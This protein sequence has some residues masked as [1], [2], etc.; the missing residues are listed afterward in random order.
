MTYGSPV[1]LWLLA[2][3]PVLAGLL[4]LSVIRRR[5]RLERLVSSELLPRLVEGWAPAS[6][7]A[8]G[9][10]RIAAIALIIL[11]LARPQWGRKDEAVV[12]RGVDIVLALDLSASMLAE[13]VVPNRLEQ[14]RA[15]AISLLT[16]LTGDRVAV[17][18]FG[19]R[20]AVHCPLT[21]DYGAAR[22]F[23]EA[24]DAAFAPAA[25]T[26]M[27]RAIES[28]RA[29]L[30]APGAGESGFKVIV[31]LTD[32]EDHEGGAL[33]A[34]RKARQ[35]G[36]VVHAV[37]VG[38]TRG[39]PIPLREEEGKLIGYKKDR[40]GKVV[41]TRLD[42]ALLEKLASSTDGTWVRAGHL[43]DAGGVIARRIAE[44][45][46][47]D[48]ASRLAARFEDRFQVPLFGAL[49][50]LGAEILWPSRRAARAQLARAL[51]AGGLSLAAAW[52]GLARGAPDAP[53]P[54]SG[55][56]ERSRTDREAAPPRPDAGTAASEP[57]GWL[58]GGSA[59]SA[60]VA[61]ANRQGNRQYDRKNYAEALARYEAAGAGAPELPAIRYNLG[62]ALYRSGKY[63][64]AASEYRRAQV[65]APPELDPA[66]R[67]NLGTAQF[68]QKAY[69]DA[70][71]NYRKV[72]RSRPTDAA[73]QRNMELALRALAA[74]EQQPPP[75]EKGSEQ[76]DPSARSDAGQSS[77]QQGE[78]QEQ[79][80]PRE[81]GGEG[82]DRR[83]EAGQQAAAGEEGQ[84]GAREGEKGKP[85]PGPEG[86]IDKKGAERLLDS[87]AQEEKK[88]LRRR[89][90]RRPREGGPEKDW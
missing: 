70:V 47:R 35:E 66:I 77:P 21:L 60:G 39:G 13:D 2:L 32:G 36:I 12:S 88:D 63:A 31:L 23:L 29:L 18:S 89:L 19:G 69:Q 75:Q 8:R 56:A 40:E 82:S 52:G 65:G 26:D 81:G 46:K 53:A 71:G 64:E 44:L 45:P 86:G 80:E 9:G 73:A 43:A 10:F 38:T 78:E 57:A 41:T 49:L 20:A 74:A 48:L 16:G 4:A 22:L 87:L 68:M 79:G 84:D 50:L 33:D 85:E 5:R 7:L 62:N 55:G 67:F 14:A 11:A 17:T 25:G 24:A 27:G 72:L 1:L 6:V 76:D 3:L 34:A 28:A 58:P 59:P 51:V 90:A 83:E 54:A 61:R 37:G 15:E 42:A 30:G